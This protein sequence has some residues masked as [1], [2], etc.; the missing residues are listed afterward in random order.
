ML[1][2]EV[3]QRTTSHTMTLTLKSVALYIAAAATFVAVPSAYATNFSLTVNGCS[4]GCGSGPFGNISVVQGGNI[5][6][7]IVTETLAA[8]N[9]Y[10]K[11][12]AG[13][14][15]GY[16][17][18]KATT[19]SG[20]GLNFTAGNSNGFSTFG[21]FATTILCSACLQGAS[22]STHISGPLSFSLFNATGL[23]PANFIRNSNNFFF[24]SDIGVP[25]GQGFDTGT[26]G[27]SVGTVTLT[28]TPE[29]GTLAMLA[30]ALGIAGVLRGKRFRA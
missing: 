17:L 25:N 24:A 30:G 21:T 7:V 13:S 15:L 2:W 11:T 29:P 9:I 19:V 28:A 27:T 5:N 12:G 10:V 26:V 16:L 18:D 14:A 3:L 6:T 22:G 4:S 1:V 20:L 8:G 23:T